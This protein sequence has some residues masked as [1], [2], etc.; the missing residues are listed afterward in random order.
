[1][2]ASRKV[3]QQ[4]GDSLA[5]KPD[6]NSCHV[7]AQLHYRSVFGNFV[8]E[9]LHIVLETMQS[10]DK[11]R[12][13]VS[14]FFKQLV[15]NERKQLFSC[16]CS[17]FFFSIISNAKRVI[18]YFECGSLP[19]ELASSI[20]TFLSVPVINAVQFCYCSCT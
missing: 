7:C 5:L 9:K 12:F 3:P 14:V 13:A 1:M 15:S 8:L 6:Q 17:N 11:N 16:H 19:T 4:A 20:D 10:T 18:F 2:L